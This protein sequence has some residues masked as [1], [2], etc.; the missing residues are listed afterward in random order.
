MVLH[1]P[2]SSNALHSFKLLGIVVAYALAL[3]TGTAL[4]IAAIGA[5]DDGRVTGP[6]G[7]RMTRAEAVMQQTAERAVQQP[8]VLLLAA[9]NLPNDKRGF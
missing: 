8:E 9:R 2:A 1:R 7:V 3:A 4:L 6:G 5:A